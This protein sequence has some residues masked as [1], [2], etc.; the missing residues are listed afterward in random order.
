[1]KRIRLTYCQVGFSHV[2]FLPC[3]Q[4]TTVNLRVPSVPLALLT[5]CTQ[6][7]FLQPLPSTC[8]C[9]TL[10][11]DTVVVQ[12]FLF[13]EPHDCKLSPQSKRGPKGKVGQEYDSA[14]CYFPFSKT[15]II[16][17]CNI[18]L[19]CW[20]NWKQVSVVAAADLHD[21]AHKNTN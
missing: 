15:R 17:F 20:G 16:Q 14:F 10:K 13:K 18:S 7:I 11:F 9:I 2:R 4:T 19:N 3:W 6:F 1:M 8:L 12:H 5:F 21:H